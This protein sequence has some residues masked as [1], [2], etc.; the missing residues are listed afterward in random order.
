ML[1]LR[2]LK[3][4]G[5]PTAVGVPVVGNVLHLAVLLLRAISGRADSLAASAVAERVARERAAARRKQRAAHASV[6]RAVATGAGFAVSSAES[7]LALAAQRRAEAE[8]ASASGADALK[9]VRAQ[10]TTVSTE[11]DKVVSTA[12]GTEI[13]RNE[14]RLRLEQMA[15]HA[16]DEYGIEPEALLSEYG[17][18]T[19]IGVPP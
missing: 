7:S 5:E 2:R 17:P 16:A 10:L 18:D 6:A 19:L 12:H 1:S 8:A 11:L 9:A 4:G 3:L 14:H 15:E 13:S